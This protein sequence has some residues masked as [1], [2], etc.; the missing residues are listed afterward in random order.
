MI[1]ARGALCAAGLTVLRVRRVG[2]I[3]AVAFRY[4]RLRDHRQKVGVRPD[5][6][7]ELRTRRRLLRR[8]YLS[9][10]RPHAAAAEPPSSALYRHGAGG[11]SSGAGG[12]RTGTGW[13]R[14][15]GSYGHAHEQ[16]MARHRPLGLR[17][18]AFLRARAESP[19]GQP[20]SFAELLGSCHSPWTDANHGSATAPLA[21][22]PRAPG[23]ATARFTSAD[24]CR[25]NAPPFPR[26][27]P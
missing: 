9:R 25:P 22:H 24:R 6:E 11:G 13:R 1:C 23:P 14:Y 4:L 16:T 27:S 2:T 3:G 19:G 10:S 21:D 17:G 15:R 26:N 18:L 12:A 20:N 8:K 5:A 7:R